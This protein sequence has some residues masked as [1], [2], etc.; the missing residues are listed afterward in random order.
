MSEDSVF[1]DQSASLPLSS[2]VRLPVS[3]TAAEVA[4]LK[5]VASTVADD[6]WPQ[7][8]R[9]LRLR[10]A[11]VHS[12]RRRSQLRGLDH[13]QTALEILL[14]WFRAQPRSSNKVKAVVVICVTRAQQELKEAIRSNYSEFRVHNMLGCFWA[15]L[16]TPLGENFDADLATMWSTSDG[17]TVRA[18]AKLIGYI[19]SV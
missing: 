17:P 12:A 8:T 10:S 13:Q 6:D 1:S 11:G 4:A 3:A 18:I 19:P 5:H 14:S 7:L 15:S 16:R 2:G 9:Y